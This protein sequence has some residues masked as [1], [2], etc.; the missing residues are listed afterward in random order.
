M[1]RALRGRQTAGPL[2]HHSD[3]SIQHCSTYCQELHERHGVTRSMTDGYALAETVNG[4]LD[5][6]FLLQRPVD[7]IQARRMVKEAVQIYNEER[8]HPSLKTQTPGAVHRASLA[9]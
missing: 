4:I 1:K 8:L 2:V 3:R 7:L 9:G 6:E 5:T